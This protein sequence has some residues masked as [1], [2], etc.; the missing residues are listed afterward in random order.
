M[1]SQQ[2]K[3]FRD[4]RTGNNIIEKRK[5]INPTMQLRISEW[6]RNNLGNDIE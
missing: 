2:I 5:D 6:R 1:K 3:I 4:P